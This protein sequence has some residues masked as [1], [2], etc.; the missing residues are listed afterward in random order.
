MNFIPDAKFGQVLDINVSSQ[1][2][3]KSYC[4]TIILQLNFNITIKEIF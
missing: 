3:K 2:V 4:I 1:H